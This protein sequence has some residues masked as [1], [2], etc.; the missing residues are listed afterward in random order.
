LP[1]QKDFGD[2]KRMPWLGSAIAGLRARVSSRRTLVIV[3][4]LALGCVASGCSSTGG[5]GVGAFAQASTGPTLAFES[6]DG[7]PPKVF[8]RL[9]NALNTESQ[10]KPVA[11]VSRGAPAAYHIRS[12]LSAQVRRGRAVIAW[13]FDVYDRDEQRALR[14]TG[15]ETAGKAGRDAWASA[16]DQLLRRIAQAG[17]SGLAAFFT[18][19]DAAPA[20]EAPQAPGRGQAIA[21]ADDAASGSLTTAKGQSVLGFNSR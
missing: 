5:Q 17:V 3:S 14:L 19:S 10:G 4:L 8:D 21:S 9:V 6:I 15:E 11:I 16:D 7:P 20:P 1:P 12:Y 18:G 13:V 2:V